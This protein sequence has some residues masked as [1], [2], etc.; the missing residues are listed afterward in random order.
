MTT[1]TTLSA[2]VFGTLTD[3]ATGEQIRPATAAELAESLRA[4]P[5]GAFAYD[6]AADGKQVAETNVTEAA[7]VEAGG[8][9]DPLAGNDR[10]LVLCPAEYNVDLIDADDILHDP[11]IRQ[12]RPGP[13]VVY[14]DGGDPDAT[15]L[16]VTS[17]EA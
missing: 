7:L 12:V 3:Y 2:A 17:D 16:T 8:G 14:V 11:D 10:V 1:N 5:E 9:T 4:G 15:G 13:L 6:Y